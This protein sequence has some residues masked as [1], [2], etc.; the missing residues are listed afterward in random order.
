MIKFL[1][2]KEC[3]KIYSTKS[4]GKDKEKFIIKGNDAKDGQF[5]EIEGFLT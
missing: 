5:K 4:E 1:N 2:S 3:G